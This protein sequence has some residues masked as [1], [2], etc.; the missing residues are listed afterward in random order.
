MFHHKT[1]TLR[2]EFLLHEI[3]ELLRDKRAHAQALLAK[4]PNAKIGRLLL[5][6]AD[7]L[8]TFFV[9]V[10]RGM[11]ELKW[12]EPQEAPPRDKNT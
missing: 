5:N 4:N 7:N 11:Y 3:R 10:F 12:V 1:N 9:T 8:E 2:L 6:E